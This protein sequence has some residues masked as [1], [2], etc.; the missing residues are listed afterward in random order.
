LEKKEKHWFGPADSPNGSYDANG[1]S[2]A[3]TLDPKL[4]VRLEASFG[5]A[6]FDFTGAH[7]G[8]RP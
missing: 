6:L 3:N 7:Y 5:R 2:I 1:R 8:L 4:V